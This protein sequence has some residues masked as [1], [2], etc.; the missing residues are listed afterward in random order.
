VSILTTSFVPDANDVYSYFYD[1]QVTTE[2]CPGNRVRYMA[3]KLQVGERPKLQTQGNVLVTRFGI[4]INRQWEVVWSSTTGGDSI[5]N[6]T[7]LDM[8]QF[9]A[10][11]YWA[12]VK[13]PCGTFLTDTLTLTSLAGVA[14][15]PWHIY[16]NPTAAGTTLEVRW[17]AAWQ[18]N[19]VVV[20]DVLGRV[21]MRREPEAGGQAQIPAALP[22]GM[23]LIELQTP[24]GRRVQKWQVW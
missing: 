21:Q 16:P 5:F 9:P 15:Q 10:S 3:R 1:W 20:R 19:A 12:K 13:T 17:P 18:V 23:Y 4:A 14:A 7:S 6:G 22:A 11:R 24:A 8:S 2:K